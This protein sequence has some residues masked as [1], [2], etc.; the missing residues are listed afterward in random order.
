[1]PFVLLT[2]AA[3]YVFVLNDF[4]LPIMV[5]VAIVMF[6]AMVGFYALPQVRTVPGLPDSLEARLLGLQ[7]WRTRPGLLVCPRGPVVPDEPGATPQSEACE[8]GVRQWLA[9]Q[10][11]PAQPQVL[12]VQRQGWRFPRPQ[13]YAY[14]VFDFLPRSAQ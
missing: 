3:L 4:G 12:T 9:E 2:L 14:A 8:R 11:Q 10:G 1:M 13:P 5:R 6:A 7:D